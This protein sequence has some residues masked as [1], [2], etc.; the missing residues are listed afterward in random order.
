MFSSKRIVISFKRFYNN[1]VFVD[2][3]KTK[4]FMMTKETNE[5][6]WATISMVNNWTTVYRENG[7]INPQYV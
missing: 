1:R 7:T 6:D 5:K 2:I 4:G 3:N